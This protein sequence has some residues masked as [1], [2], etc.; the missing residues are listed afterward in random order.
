[1]AERD[2]PELA[3]YEAILARL[4]KATALVKR[5]E[6]A[7]QEARDAAGEVAVEALRKALKIGRKRART[8]VLKRSPF[9]HTT[10]RDIAEAAGIAPDERYVRSPKRDDA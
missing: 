2:D 9:S 8:E 7:A 5:R 6:D 4:D 3:E 10:L 1:M